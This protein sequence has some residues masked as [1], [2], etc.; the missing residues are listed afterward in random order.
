MGMLS[1][2]VSPKW[3]QVQALKPICQDM[4][5]D[6]F[7]NARPGPWLLPD[8]EHCF[9]QTQTL[10]CDPQPQSNREAEKLKVLHSILEEIH[11]L[12]GPI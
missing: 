9:T 4:F 11:R 8:M 7:P 10:I 2:P 1:S 5:V 6:F 3:S 12:P